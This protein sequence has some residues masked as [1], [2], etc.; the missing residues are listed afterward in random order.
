MCGT[1][2]PPAAKTSSPLRTHGRGYVLA[3]VS[4]RSSQQGDPSTQRCSPPSETDLIDLNLRPVEAKETWSVDSDCAREQAGSDFA[5][6]RNQKSKMR[7]SQCERGPVRNR[8]APGCSPRTRRS[9][10]CQHCAK[11]FELRRSSFY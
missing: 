8:N 9:E 2:Y 1:E 7:V 10:I 6:C 11:A 5:Q 3:A 4:L